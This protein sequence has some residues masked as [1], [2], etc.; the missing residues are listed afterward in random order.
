MVAAQ[1]AC[2]GEVH[3]GVAWHRMNVGDAAMDHVA[4]RL[5]GSRAKVAEVVSPDSPFGMMPTLRHRLDG[6]PSTSVY[7]MPGAEP[8]DGLYVDCTV[9]AA[10]VARFTARDWHAIARAAVV[11][12][13]EDA[14]G[15]RAGG[16]HG[17]ASALLR[18]VGG[19]SHRPSGVRGSRRWGCTR[20]PRG[21]TPRRRR[22][23]TAGRDD[24]PDGPG[25]PSGSGR[26]TAVQAVAAHW[27]LFALGWPTE[28]PSPA[29]AQAAFMRARMVTR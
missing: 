14:V 12:S 4:R 2:V 7:V 29:R 15:L 16:L 8:A 25:E 11:R 26:L 23:T 3:G 21:R 18:R 20:V 19:V 13:R 22:A 17:L 1:D 9:F 24:G 5:F 28:D 27:T 6:C 10:E